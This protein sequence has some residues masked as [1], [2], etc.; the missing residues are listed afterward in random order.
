MILYIH[1]FASSGEGAKATLFKTLACNHPVYAPSLSN[2]PDLA[3]QTL[4]ECITLCKKSEDPLFS[5]VHII[6]SSL[7]GYYAHY[8]AY[9]YRLKAVLINPALYP[10][11]RL[12]SYE[13]MVKNYYDN[14][15][16]ECHV[17]HFEML[18]KYDVPATVENDNILLLSQKG[19]EVLDYREAV[20]K[21]GG[22]TM[23]VQDGGDHTFENITDYLDAIGT[24]LHVRFGGMS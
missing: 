5:T 18:K 19:D 17:T 21:L 2:I 20:G 12:S 23:M 7:G 1:G 10:Y 4:S 8:L 13:G 6:G 3:I 9:K 11:N 16:F 24:F 14:S 22:A 15:H